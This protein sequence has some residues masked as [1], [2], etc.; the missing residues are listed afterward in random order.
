[1]SEYKEWKIHQ[2]EAWAM[3]FDLLSRRTKRLVKYA[4]MIDIHGGTLLLRKPAYSLFNQ[5][6][7]LYPSIRGAASFYHAAR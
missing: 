3:V 5:R 4:S 7:T 1:M 6:R 2:Y